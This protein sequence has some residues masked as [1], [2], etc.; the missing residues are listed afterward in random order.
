MTF[1]LLF[2]KNDFPCDRTI[3]YYYLIFNAWS[4]VPA[5]IPL[6]A[7]EVGFVTEESQTVPVHL[8]FGERTSGMEGIS[9]G[10]VGSMTYPD[11]GEKKQAL[12]LAFL[13]F[14]RK[15]SRTFATLNV[16]GWGL[17]LKLLRACKCVQLD[18]NEWPWGLLN[19]I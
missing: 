2:N 15:G 1:T 14:A 10:I 18:R 5:R 7:D 6:G 13:H 16:S 8:G 19:V 4:V 17:E 3:Y 9:C 12:E 11:S